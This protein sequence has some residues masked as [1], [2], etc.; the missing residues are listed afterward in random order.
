V[1]GTERVVFEGMGDY[2]VM[3]GLGRRLA[4]ERGMSAR[5]ALAREVFGDRLPFY[6][7]SDAADLVEAMVCGPEDL[8]VLCAKRVDVAALNA[9]KERFG[10][11]GPTGL[12]IRAELMRRRGELRDWTI[13]REGSDTVAVRVSGASE[14]SVYECLA[15]DRVTRVLS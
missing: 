13:V 14:D 5:E 4:E 9:V 1:S 12:A 2:E 10:R 15:T 11:V 7:T 3:V 6:V 8:I